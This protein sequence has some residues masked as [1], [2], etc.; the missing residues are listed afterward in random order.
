MSGAEISIDPKD[1]RSATILNS[2]PLLT[3]YILG[4]ILLSLP[5]VG[6]YE[7]EM[8]RERE[9]EREE[10]E[11][12]KVRER[13]VRPF[14]RELYV[15]TQASI[16]NV[17]LARVVSKK[18]I[19]QQH[20][21]ESCSRSPHGPPNLARFSALPHYGEAVPSTHALSPGVHL[22]WS[23]TPCVSHIYFILPA[24]CT[25]IPRPRDGILYQAALSQRGDL[26]LSFRPYTHSRLNR[27]DIELSNVFIF[28]KSYAPA[29]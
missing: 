6:S 12:E 27:G 14:L 26:R 29:F 19:T 8:E 5:T 1:G 24:P 18:S 3:F 21:R 23:A 22:F 11:G 20:T 25:T 7:G 10:E 28:T 16:Y 9:R 17:P 15:R 13:G 4:R 2:T